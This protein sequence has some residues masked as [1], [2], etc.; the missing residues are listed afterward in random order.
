MS[1]RFRQLPVTA[2]ALVA[3][4]LLSAC[5]ADDLN[6]VVLS[7][8]APGDN[9]DFPDDTLYVSRGSLDLRPYFTESAATNPARLP[10]VSDQY[11]QVFSWQNNLSSVPITVNSQVIDP[12][13]GNDFIADTA[14]YSYQYSDPS[15]TLASESQNI[16]AVIPAGGKT[17]DSSVPAD[18][19]QPNAFA[20]INAST[21]IDTSSQTLLVTLQYFGKLA[22]G[23]PTKNTNK[24]TFPLTIYRSSTGA[25]DCFAQTPGAPPAGGPCRTPG[26]DAPVQCTTP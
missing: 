1:A 22:A 7:A 26:R 5:S 18:L 23:G 21:A 9:C 6:I 20:A 15:V 2:L 13:Q 17:A 8:R 12:G 25:L 24:V 11:Y 16:R 4:S 19:I 14:V 10:V 3:A